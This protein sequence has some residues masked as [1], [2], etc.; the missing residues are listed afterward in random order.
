MDW[1][2]DVSPWREWERAFFESSNI[3]TALCSSVI[4]ACILLLWYFKRKDARRPILL[5]LFAW[6][7]F[8]LGVS[9]IVKVHLFQLHYYRVIMVVDL[10]AAIPA[11][12]V[13]FTVPFMTIAALRYPP[14]NVFEKTAKEKQ[15]LEVENV[16]L[17]SKMLEKEQE[18]RHLERE[19]CKRDEVITKI[20]D[21]KPIDVILE[22]MDKKLED[23]D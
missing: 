3:I 1:L 9:Q 18:A 7:L 16:V 23:R 20:T 8:S 14:L 6:F 5:I 19:I 21:S 22:K 12:V 10:L 17:Q 15:T 13:F 11:L 4:S 2:L